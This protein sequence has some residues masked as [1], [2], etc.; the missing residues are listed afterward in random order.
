MNNYSLLSKLLHWSM[1]LAMFFLFGLGVYM[2]DLGY[3]DSNYTLSYS[4]HKAVGMI[5]LFVAAI[6]LMWAIVHKGPD[7]VSTLRN[8]ERVSAALMHKLLFVLIVFIPL[9]GYVIAAAVGQS[10][11]I[12]GLIEI[13]AFFPDM[14]K[15]EDI[16]IEDIASEAHYYLAYGGAGFVVLHLL[17]ALKHHFV[18]K[19]R[20]LRRMTF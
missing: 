20:T 5:V 18:D 8:W 10:V 6:Q 9:S 13:P 17:A 3:Y 12:F 4:V 19:D 7:M 16:A 11:D 1:A 2:I 15:P 14:F